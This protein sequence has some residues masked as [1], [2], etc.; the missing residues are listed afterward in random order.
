M[1]DQFEKSKFEDIDYL[2]SMKGSTVLET[3]GRN[4]LAPSNSGVAMKHYPIHKICYKSST[5]DKKS[6]IN[7]ALH[8]V[9][10]NL[11]DDLKYANEDNAKIDIAFFKASD[12]LQLIFAQLESPNTLGIKY[13]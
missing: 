6:T 8:N 9:G 11:K 13:A 5:E 1:D 3:V 2:F 4:Y 12:T 7:N 10:M